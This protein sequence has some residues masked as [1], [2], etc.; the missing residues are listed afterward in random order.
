MHPV[1]YIE[2][3]THA[4]WPTPK[5]SFVGGEVHDGEGHSYL[6]LLEDDKNLGELSAVLPH[7]AH[8]NALVVRY[9]GL[10]GAEYQN[11]AKPP[12]GPTQRCQWSYSEKELT[13]TK[14]LKNACSWE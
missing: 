7:A 1:V 14:P 13:K 9:N 5:G 11:L 8:P 4:F 10:W 3:D 12:L 2:K 6:T